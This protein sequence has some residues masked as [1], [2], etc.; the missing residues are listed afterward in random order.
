MRR[1]TAVAN[2]K[3]SPGPELKHGFAS[4]AG[5]IPEYDV[6]RSM[7]QRCSESAHGEDRAN[8]YERGLRVCDAWQASFE[9]FI[10]D[11]GR[12]PSPRHS[13]DR[14]DNS[15]GYS[16]EN[17]RWSTPTEQ[18]NNRRPRRTKEVSK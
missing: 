15:K 3:R 16:P 17:C 7:R 10:R 1:E 18:A 13:L 12:R 6:W 8:Y 2:G 14:I 9:A 11:M 5:R 4:N